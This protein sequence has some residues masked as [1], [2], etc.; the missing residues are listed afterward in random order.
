VLAVKA[1][2]KKTLLV[3]EGFERSKD[4]GE[5]KLDFKT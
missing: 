1:A 3:D 2:Q 4:H 5:G